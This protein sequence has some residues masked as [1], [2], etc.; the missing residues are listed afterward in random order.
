M[1]PEKTLAQIEEAL[2][3]GV[4]PEQINAK[5]KRDYGYD[6]VDELRKQV[7]SDPFS[8]SPFNAPPAAG[9]SAVAGRRARRGNRLVPGYGQHRASAAA[10]TMRGFTQEA[11][12]GFAD[13]IA[14]GIAGILP[15]GKSAG[16]AL[17]ESRAKNKVAKEEHRGAYMG[18]Q[19][20]G[21]MASFAIPVGAA[22]K[23]ARIMQAG[24]RRAAQAAN[25]IPSMSGLDP[26]S[27]VAGQTAQLFGAHASKLMGNAQSVLGRGLLGG[28]DYFR[29]SGKIPALA[30]RYAAFRGGEE[31]LRFFG[32]QE[33]KGI[34][35]VG[36]AVELGARM[37]AGALTGVAGGVVAPSLF[38]TKGFL[39]GER[40]LFKDMHPSAKPA[41]AL[42]DQTGIHQK[43][44]Q[45]LQGLAEERRVISEE[46]YSKLD[47]ADY[48]ADK[49]DGFLA[50]L[51][52]NHDTRKLIATPS[53]RAHADLAGMR[54]TGVRQAMGE[55]NG[56][57][58]AIARQT[59][60]VNQLSDDARG[61]RTEIA[62]AASLAQ[63]TSLAN[64]QAAF[65][66]QNK[67]ADLDDQVDLVAYKNLGDA[68]AM[69]RLR[70][71]TDVSK[72]NADAAARAGED[73]ETVGGMRQQY[74]NNLRNILGL[75]EERIPTQELLEN[76]R[77]DRRQDLRMLGR[78][79]RGERLGLLERQGAVLD[80]REA[81]GDVTNRLADERAVLRELRADRRSLAQGLPNPRG[82]EAIT[83]QARTP[84]FRDLQNIRSALRRSGNR[85]QVDAMNQAMEEAYGPEF[86]A[87]NRA[88]EANI[89]TENALELGRKSSSI[90]EDEVHRLFD[91]IGKGRTPMSP[92]ERQAFNIGRVENLV[93]ELQVSEKPLARFKALVNSGPEMRASLRTMFP[94]GPVGDANLD[95]FLA[96]TR[97]ANSGRIVLT[98]LA[99]YAVF[100]A[101]LK[102]GASVFLAQRFTGT[103]GF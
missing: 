89:K 44:N 51:A 30:T 71:D 98:A 10:A 94:Q 73:P 66:R 46:M 61:A 18:G 63:R 59:R 102:S 39:R 86:A 88:Y 22:A 13:E 100:Q 60:K 72:A 4:D 6:S 3:A 83:E 77:F 9:D 76:L 85:E 58:D 50:E 95:R 101:S 43:M 29:G 36:D 54:Q 78:Q 7:S 56:L 45:E 49:M 21:M 17:A 37:G 47:E 55:L 65:L 31:G 80:A 41:A 38:G 34:H 70:K 99:A 1:D 42:R 92:R 25:K 12:L 2:A 74:Y 67:G 84:T 35:N 5:L 19:G 91:G 57:D 81:A 8:D 24:A 75:R 28:R 16:E 82:V 52:S 62:D 69:R 79:T 15:G 68:Q 93:A 64:R 23:G 40:G 11:T 33:D 27:S 97:E 90:A 103:A 53:I 87:A 20:L 14:A 48:P 32:Q 26:A 96:I